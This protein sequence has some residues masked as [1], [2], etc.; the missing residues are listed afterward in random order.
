MPHSVSYSINP[1]CLYLLPL[2]IFL[3]IR[4]H[5]SNPT[6]RVLNIAF[7]A[8]NQVNVNVKNALPCGFANVYAHVEAI[9]VETLRQ[10]FFAMVHQKPQGSLFTGC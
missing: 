3:F 5:P 8:R 4:Y 1:I 7:I 6:F 2:L 10:Q 9:G